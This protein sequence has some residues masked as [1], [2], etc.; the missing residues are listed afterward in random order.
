MIQP[1]QFKN[2][3]INQLT[4]R[5]MSFIHLDHHNIPHIVKDHLLRSTLSFT[6]QNI[7]HALNNDYSKQLIPLIGLFTI[8]E[9]LG[10]CYDRMDISNIRFQNNIKRALVNFGGIDQNDELIDVLYALRNSL[11]HSASLISHGENSANKDKHYR[12]RYSSEIQHIIQESKVK[13]NGCYEE[14]DGNTEKYT[15]LINVDLLV[16]FVFSCIEKA[17]ALNQENLLRLRLEGGVRQLYFD[18]IKSNPLL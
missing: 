4:I 12:F 14:L 3:Y 16:K 13:W 5:E 18:Y 10:K 8:L 7:R 15:T 9:Q 17:S 6:S 2:K 1:I 11:L